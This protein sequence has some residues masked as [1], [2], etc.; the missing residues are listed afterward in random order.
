MTDEEAQAAKGLTAGSG[1][2][3]LREAALSDCALAI[4]HGTSHMARQN[5][6]DFHHSRCSRADSSDRKST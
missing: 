5:G 6:M 3:F 2:P 1:T 4:M